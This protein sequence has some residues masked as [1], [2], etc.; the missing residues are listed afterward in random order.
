MNIL[1]FG[2]LLNHI[3]YLLIE[4]TVEKEAAAAR[5]AA[6]ASS[7]NG[8][9][10][11][12]SNNTGAAVTS[13]SNNGAAASSSNDCTAVAIVNASST[14]APVPYT[15]HH[16]PQI[17]QSLTHSPST[18]NPKPSHQVDIPIAA[19]LPPMPLI[20]HF[21]WLVGPVPSTLSLYQVGI[22]EGCLVRPR[23]SV[24]D[25]KVTKDLVIRRHGASCLHVQHRLPSVVAI[26][27]YF[28]I[29]FCE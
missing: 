19:T 29:R 27:R 10:A 26:L 3:K 25:P 24:R 22:C 16:K 14:R 18:L 12:S 6:A 8:A 13:S 17:L 20:V 2:S 23:G 11:T 28:Q 4:S 21:R 9:A 7:N 15:L 5:N 1:G